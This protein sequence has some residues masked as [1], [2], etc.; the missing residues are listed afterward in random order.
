[1]F[2]YLTGRIGIITKTDPDFSSF[3]DSGIF[4]CKLSRNFS[5]EKK[6]ISQERGIL[7]IEIHQLELNLVG[8]F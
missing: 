2:L 3:F 7:A 8:C 5:Q 6:A 4:L 1:M